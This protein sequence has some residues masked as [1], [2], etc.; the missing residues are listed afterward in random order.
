LAGR[1]LQLQERLAVELS[2]LPGQSTILMALR[3]YPGAPQRAGFEFKRIINENDQRLWVRPV[4]P[5]GLWPRA[6]RNPASYV[7]Y[8]VGFAG[9]PV[10]ASA[11]Q[12]HLP[13]L[14]SLEVEG[15]PRATIYRAR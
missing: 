12:Y 9:D 6:L 10:D 5:E 3:D 2:R 13:A 4:D 1:V 7:D 14:L 11:R 15:Q 8:A